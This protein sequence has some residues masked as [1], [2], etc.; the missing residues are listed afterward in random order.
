[1][2][3]Y[4]HKMR[5]LLTRKPE[6]VLDSAADEEEGSAAADYASA[7]IRMKAASILQEF[8]GTSTDD[9]A[10]GESLAD[11]LLMLVVGIIDSDKDGELSDDEQ[12]AA[13]ALLESMWDYLLDKGVSDEDCNALL[14]D[15][16]ADAAARVRDLL[17]DSGVSGDD[18]AALDDLDAFAFDTDAEQSVFD[19]AGELITDA[20]YRKKVVVRAGKKVRIN[21]RISGAVR[22]SAKQKV[23]VRKM[24]RK[25]HSAAAMMRRM[26]SLRIRK[27]A[28]L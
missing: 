28:G 23:A 3:D 14:N 15:W 1:M 9:L 12:A 18:D 10:D 22:L 6:V 7:D 26:K 19:S 11:R 25:S 13:D 8:A 21:K 24:I 5:T 16:D 4:K 20:V 17:A 2:I 27:R